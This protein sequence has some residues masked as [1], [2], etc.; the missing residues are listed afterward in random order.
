MNATVADS[1]KHL[2]RVVR[3]ALDKGIRVRGYVS[4]VIMCP[5]SSETDFWRVWDVTRE[6]LDMICYEVSLGDTTGM[7]NPT[8][9]SGMLNVTRGES[10]G[11]KLTG[12][13]CQYHFVSGDPRQL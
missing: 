4:V 10:G 2:E 13:V 11:K 5:Y 8:S 3:G 7:A 1:R 12:H 9:V 6:L